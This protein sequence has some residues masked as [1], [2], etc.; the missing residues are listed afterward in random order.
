MYVYGNSKYPF[1]QSSTDEVHIEVQSGS[2]QSNL[3]EPSRDQQAVAAR[4]APVAEK[5]YRP[6]PPRSSLATHLYMALPNQ[7]GVERKAVLGMSGRGRGNMVWQ[8][9]TGQLREN[10]LLSFRISVNLTYNW[11]SPHF[12][13][14]FVG[15]RTVCLQQWMYCG[16]RGSLQQ[17]AD[18][19]HR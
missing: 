8:P 12:V 10:S 9:T 17:P 18:P 4:S 7:A 15:C 1:P 16:G 19:S 14:L 11:E 6:H 3:S 2:D 5:H 13:C